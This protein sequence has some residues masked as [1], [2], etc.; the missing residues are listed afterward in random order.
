MHK[1]ISDLEK[2]LQQPLPGRDAQLKMSHVVRK[3]YHNPPVDARV[4]CVLALFYPKATISHLALIVRDSSNPNDNHGGQVGFPGGK[5]EEED[6][7]LEAAA[8]REAEEEIGIVAKDVQILGRLTE[9]YIPV[10]NF[11]VHPFVG[12]LDYTPAF[13][14]QETE[15]QSIIEVPFSQFYSPE[16]VQTTDLKISNNITLK[17]VP[18]FDIEGKIVW[19]ATA[20]MLS[21]LL[22]VAN[23][24]K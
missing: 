1:F 3:F 24:K 5:R 21:E 16:I 9:L 8:L 11:V 14:P 19:G 10:S 4:A 12:F 23:G 17:H 15:V 7:S 18:Y 13:V 22:E 6:H 2:Q 20:M